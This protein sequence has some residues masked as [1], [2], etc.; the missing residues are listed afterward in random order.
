MAPLAALAAALL[1]GLFAFGAS[2]QNSPSGGSQR[3][4]TLRPVS[5]IAASACGVQSACLGRGNETVD[6]PAASEHVSLA[7]CTHCHAASGPAA[8]VKQAAARLAESCRLC[9]LD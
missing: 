3:L 4:W 2:R 8:H 7:C 9:H 6:G 5:R 1:V